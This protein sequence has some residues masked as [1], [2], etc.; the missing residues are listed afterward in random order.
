MKS[1]IFLLRTI[2]YTITLTAWPF[3]PYM[4]GHEYVEQ[5]DRSLK[6]KICGK[7]SE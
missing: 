4:S 1:I 2:W 6:C 5:D 7:I 3:S